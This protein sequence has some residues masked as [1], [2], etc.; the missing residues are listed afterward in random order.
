MYFEDINDKVHFVYIFVSSKGMGIF[1][2]NIF[3]R[4]LENGRYLGK[5]VEIA[6]WESNRKGKAQ[7]PCEAQTQMLNKSSLH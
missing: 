5:E 6:S 3:N 4:A 1:C 7:I 2:S